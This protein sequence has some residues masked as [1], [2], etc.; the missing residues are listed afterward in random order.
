MTDAIQVSTTAASEDAAWALVESMVMAK[1][2]AG[3]QVHGPVRS[4]FWHEGEYGTGEEWQVLLKTTAR[5]YGE[6]EAQL[7][8]EH[9]WSNPEITAVPI[10]HASADY[11]RWLSTTL[12]V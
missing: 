9:A 2:A 8:A 1:L 4:A 7:R 6:L 11:L 5:R 3:G 12:A 10:T